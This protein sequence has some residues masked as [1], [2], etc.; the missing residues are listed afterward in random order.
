MKIRTF[1]PDRILQITFAALTLIFLW[2][3]IKYAA[4]WAIAA[5]FICFVLTFFSCGTAVECLADNEGILI[6][7]LY[8]KRRISYSDIQWVY[9]DVRKGSSS[10]GSSYVSLIHSITFVTNQGNFTCEAQHG[11]LPLHSMTL[12]SE[13]EKAALLADSPFREFESYVKNRLPGLSEAG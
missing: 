5:T 12:Y 4:V 1:A 6:K 8:S 2:A 11:K 7:R 3:L 10:K 13:T 9:T